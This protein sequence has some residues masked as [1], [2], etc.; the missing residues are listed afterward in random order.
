MHPETATEKLESYVMVD[1]GSIDNSRNV[2]PFIIECKDVEM[3]LLKP[4]P[5]SIEVGKKSKIRTGL[6]QE[7]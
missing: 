7:V 1:N 2:L 6:L 5:S 3:P 4:R